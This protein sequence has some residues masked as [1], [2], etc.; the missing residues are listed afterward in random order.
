MPLCIGR[1]LDGFGVV[2]NAY[3]VRHLGGRRTHG[4]GR[5]SSMKQE[6]GRE[7]STNARWHAAVVMAVAGG[8]CYPFHQI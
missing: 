7:N 3:P 6:I 5:R 2:I 1:E 8:G 4:Y